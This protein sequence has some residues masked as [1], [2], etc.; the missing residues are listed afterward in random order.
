[1]GQKAGDIGPMD[2]WYQGPKMKFARRT[3]L[4]TGCG[5]GREGISPE[6]H[7]LQ[8]RPVERFHHAFARGAMAW[9][10]VIRLGP[11]AV[12]ADGGHDIIPRLNLTI[13]DT[14]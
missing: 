14:G 3:D 9:Q 10:Q 4:E 7:V 11:M 1:M 8:L 5:C 2:S 13:D 12:S 6:G